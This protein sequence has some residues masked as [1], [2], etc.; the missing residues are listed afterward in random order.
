MKLQKIYNEVI[1]LYC[2]KKLKPGTHLLYQDM[3]EYAGFSVSQQC[4][5]KVPKE[6]FP[7][8]PDAFTA[9]HLISNILTNFRDDK[10][11]PGKMGDELIKSKGWYR[12]FHSEEDDIKVFIEKKYASWIDKTDIVYVHKDYEAI[13]VLGDDCTVIISGLR[14]PHDK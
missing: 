14:R 10:F 11:I 9:T 7:F 12:A 1:K 5:F 6:K 4:A 3:G 13:K 8:M 2:A